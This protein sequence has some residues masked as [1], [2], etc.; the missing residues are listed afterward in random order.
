MLELLANFRNIDRRI[1]SLLTIVVLAVPLVVRIPLPIH[2]FPATTKLKDYIDRLPK[3]KIVLLAVDW[4]SGTRGECRP[5]T[6]A[7]IN[8]LMRQDRKFAIFS[9]VPQGPE[10]TEDLAE[11]DAAQFHKTYGKDWVNWGYRPN[12]L[13]TLIG[14]MNDVAGAMKTD[15]RHND[16][17]KDPITQQV[18]SLKDCG[19]LMEIT[20]TGLLNTYLQ[21]CAGVPMAN[22]CTAV[23]GPETYPYLQ[24]G[25]LQGLLVGL[26]GAAQF[27]SITD[28]RNAK[29]RPGGEGGVGMG[30]QSMG[31]LLVMILIVL[32]NLG[33]W[34]AKKLP[35]SDA[36][37]ERGEGEA[38]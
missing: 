37:N 30:S 9:F 27:E 23:I 35:P 15:I 16:L 19:L 14:M 11:A 28:Y 24:S 4:D 7:M 25:Q 13:V 22:G 17:T 6:E 8:Y 5:Q 3:D 33:V 38:S 26:G 31:H 10:L 32:G 2:A 21:F 36:P 20:G 34:A 18:K 29:G 1:V 12:P